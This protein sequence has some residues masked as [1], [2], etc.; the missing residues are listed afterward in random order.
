MGVIRNESE[1]IETTRGQKQLQKFQWK[2]T[3]KRYQMKKKTYFLVIF[4]FFS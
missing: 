4:V 1:K 2:A 3:E